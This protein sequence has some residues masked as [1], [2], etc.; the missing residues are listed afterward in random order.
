[1]LQELQQ[2]AN[3]QDINSTLPSTEALSS[4]TESTSKGTNQEQMVPVSEAIK[5]RKRAQTAEQQVQQLTEKLQNSQQI[6]QDTQAQ[7]NE[8]EL[9]NKLTQELVQAG[10]VDV[11]AALLLA[12]KRAET[13]QDNYDVRGLIEAL[14]NER[15]YLFSHPVGEVSASLAAP[16]AGVRSSGGGVNNLLRSAQRAQQ[17][18]SRRDMHEY[19][20][21]RRAVQ[22]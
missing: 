20:R 1:M 18:G 16:T 3:T 12:Q 15:P 10:V 21:M 17:S 8:K 5:Y 7:L 13:C 11:E 14:R 4:E 2:Q 19:L 9:E 22:R 6:Q